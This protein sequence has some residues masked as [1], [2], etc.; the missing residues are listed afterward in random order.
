MLTNLL[1]HITPWEVPTGLLLFLAGMLMGILMM[2]AK[3]MTKDH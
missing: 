2:L 1:A 3:Q